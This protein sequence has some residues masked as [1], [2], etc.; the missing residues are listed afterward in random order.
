M[1][2]EFDAFLNVMEIPNYLHVDSAGYV[3][4]QISW[5]ETFNEVQIKSF[6]VN[7]AKTIWSDPIK[8]KSQKVVVLQCKAQ[9]NNNNSFNILAL[10][11]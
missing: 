9:A 5:A 10:L 3:T 2:L 4:C 7:F 1:G 11:Y 6:S 8:F